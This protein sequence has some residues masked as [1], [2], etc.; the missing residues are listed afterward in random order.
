M[1]ADS[2]SIRA[3]RELLDQLKSSNRAIRATIGG[4]EQWAVVEDASR[5]RDALG[6]PLPIGVPTAFIEP[7]DDPVGDLVGRYARTHGPFTVQ[8][9]ASRFGLGTAVVLD[10]L[11]RLAADKR[12]VDGEFRP[13]A[14]GSEWCSVEVL[15][16]L[17]SR[18]LAALRQEVEPVPQ[19]ALA[20]FLPEWQHVSTGSGGGALRGVDGLR[21]GD[22]PARGGRA[23]GIRVGDPRAAR[24]AARTT[25]RRGSTSS[26]RAARSSGRAPARCP[27]TTAG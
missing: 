3:L 9:V 17:R 13:G 12:V 15:R 19:D 7:V 8:D 25:R 27:A 1:A 10:T 23:A 2:V 20:R 14:T 16:R 18:S 22:R 5:L 4:A 6:V 26:P 21:A 11:K 24:P